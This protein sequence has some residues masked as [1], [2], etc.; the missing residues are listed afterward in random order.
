MVVKPTRST[1]KTDTR[2]RSE[3][4]TSCA[5]G[6]TDGAAGVSAEPH[7]PQKRSPGSFAVPQAG[8]SRARAP[9]AIR[10]ELAPLTVLG[11]TVR[12]DHVSSKRSEEHTSELQ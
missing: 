2:R 6:A 1:N 9:P 5:A 4:G 8:Q 7:S 11:A 3:A 10:A 12:A